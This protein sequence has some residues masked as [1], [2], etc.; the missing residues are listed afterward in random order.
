[1]LISVLVLQKIGKTISLFVLHQLTEISKYVRNC[2]DL[3]FKKKK[4]QFKDT[5]TQN[6][7]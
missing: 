6:H 4:F 1:M 7:Q 3:M 2:K 5:G